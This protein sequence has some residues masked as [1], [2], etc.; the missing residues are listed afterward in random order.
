MAH[1]KNGVTKRTL[2]TSN[3]THAD[4]I[5]IT[6]ERVRHAGVVPQRYVL[7]DHRR[8]FL[9]TD[10]LRWRDKGLYQ[11]FPQA[12]K[13]TVHGLEP[14]PAGSWD[15]RDVSIYGT[16]LV[17]NGLWRMWYLCMPD[18]DSHEEN[19][20]HSYVCY[21]ESDDGIHWR[22]PD[23]G[24]TGQ[25]RYPGNNILPLPGH[26]QGV[27]EALPGSDFKYLAV[28]VQIN[29]L[30]P[31]ICDQKK[32]G[33]TYNTG[34]T[35]LFASDD[36]FHW[37]QLSKTPLIVHGDNC[38]LVADAATSRYFLYQK[39]GLLHGLDMHR[40]WIGLES[41]DGVHWEGY[42]GFGTMRECFVA[43]DYDNLIAAQRGLRLADH[44]CIGAGRVGDLYVGIE[45]MFLVGD[46]L[47][48]RF[49]QNPNG[50]AYVRLAYS[51]NGF[52]W[53]HPTGRPPWIE[54]GAPGS[55]D[56]G[57]MVTSNTFVEHGEHTL[58]Y[59]T[60]CKYD[61]GWSINT[62]FSLDRSI[63]LAEQRD[64]ARIGLARIKRDRF[65]SLGAAHRTR[66][67]VINLTK[68][69]ATCGRRDLVAGPR[70]GN[71]LFINACCPN[72]DVR[73][74]LA[75][76]LQE[77]PLPGFSFDDCVPFSGDGVK[78]PVRFRKASVAQIPPDTG[79]TVRFEVTRGEIFGYEWGEGE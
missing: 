35:H 36:G 9:D 27:V 11:R 21:A 2:R 49:A 79:L 15:A 7:D 76:Y 23:L 41:P 51:H 53:R 20:D 57:F 77:K 75:A 52:N 73:V 13:V 4:A 78:S 31:D 54:L 33:F 60:V 67:E 70:G 72:G 10:C 16:V 18:A 59:Y 3:P 14:G 47:V 65:A 32:W 8:I 26:L 62:D 39:M 29:R 64:T 40:S 56:A 28:T 43:D 48:P 38:C 68:M 46:P 63:P 58:L 25:H 37:R 42:N 69:E 5:K 55:V 44:Y 34:G 50:L 30:E 71:E 74:E 61:H 66:F 12:E 24:L 19:P 6:E 45:S 17:E 1:K 22:K